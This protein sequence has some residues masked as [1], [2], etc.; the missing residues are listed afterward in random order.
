MAYASFSSPF[1]PG[2]FV[3]LVG[4]SGAGKDTLLNAARAQ[5]AGRV[6]FAFPQRRITRKPSA[7]EDNVSISWKEYRRAVQEG[8]MALAWEAHG[9]GYIIPR[10]AD[11]EVVAGRTV[12][13]NISRGAT[14]AAKARYARCFVAY[15]D[16][17]V[18]IRASRLAGRLRESPREVLLRLERT[19][20][21][22]DS[23]I[24]DLIIDN[25][26]TLDQGVTALVSFLLETVSLYRAST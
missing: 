8:D 18:E 7:S 11:R 24:A 16:A 4:P 5:L 23:H 9:L 15:I 14:A 25:G 21:G 13:T 22:S 6:E 19:P 17:P 12:V 10:E 20:Q 1:G 26:G 2:S 3:A